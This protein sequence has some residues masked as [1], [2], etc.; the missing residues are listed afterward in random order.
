MIIATHVPVGVS[1]MDVTTNYDEAT[2]T[3]KVMILDG[4]DLDA[5]PVYTAALPY[6]VP[7]GLHSSFIDW[8]HMSPN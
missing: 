5:G 4:D 2:L 3:S 8:K 7:Y 6:H 1:W